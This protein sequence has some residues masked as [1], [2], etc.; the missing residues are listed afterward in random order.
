MANLAPIQVEQLQRIGDYLR[1]VRQEQ[2]LSLDILANQI[3][4]RPALLQAL[5]TG[6]E[7]QLPEPVFIQGFIRRYAEALGLDGKAI[8]QEFVVTPPP[9]MTDSS[10]ATPAMSYGV[11]APAPVA[12]P[13][14]QP[15]STP[16]PTVVQTPAPATVEKPVVAPEP[17]PAPTPIP[18]PEPV[19]SAASMAA[20]SQPAKAPTSTVQNAPLSTSLPP[21][22][23]LPDRRGGFP[24]WLLMVGAIL[25][26]GGGIGMVLG[27]GQAPQTAEAPTEEVTPAEPETPVIPEPEPEPEPVALE[28]PIVVAVQL[29]ER[30]WLSVVADGRTVYEGTSESG[31]EET[32]TAQNSLV[33]TTG[34]AG[35]VSFSFNGED[36]VVLGNSGAVRTLRLNPNSNA[37]ELAT[38]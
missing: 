5:E 36:P 19:P 15:Q 32:W 13:A 7:D 9:M 27:R 16:A 14:P 8:S 28:A 18:A 3:F 34:N 29:T 6:R 37:A 31:Y 11:A 17:I 24:L 23:P 30:S 21:M 1:Q 4:I 35:G 22:A 38:P 2:G 20:A 26:I 10:A 25:L 33:F 12:K